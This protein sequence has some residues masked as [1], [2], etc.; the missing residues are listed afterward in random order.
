MS[1]T[2]E[3]VAMIAMHTSPTAQ[4]GTADAG[5][6]NVAVLGIAAELAIRG[7][8]VDLL[9]RAT[10]NPGVSELIP[11]VTLHELAAGPS[12]VLEKARMPEVTDE[13]GEA[14]GRLARVRNYDLLHAHYWLSGIA[15]LPVSIE[16][17]RP[18]V[19]NFH[20]LGAMKNSLAG[21]GQSPEPVQ[22]IRSEMFL[23]TQVDAIIAAS[24][25]EA[26]ALIDDVGAPPDRTWIIPP[27]VDLDMFSPRAVASHAVTRTSLGLE[28]DRP[29]VVIAGR[30]QPL[31]GHELAVRALAELHRLRGWAP[32]LVIAGEVT[33]GDEAFAGL[34]RTLA[35]E[36]GVAADVRFV[37]ALHRDALAGLLAAAALTIVPSF[38][39]T[40]G[41]V[42]LESAASGTPVLAYRAGGLP[43]AV[44]EGTSGLLLGTR[45]PRYWATEMAV[46]IEDDDRRAALGVSAR[47]FA[48]RFTWG[49]AATSLLGVYAGVKR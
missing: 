45:E 40:F 6:L 13:F 49:A 47:G 38:S 27:G 18:L 35:A 7:V 17:A 29:I 26:T 30:V 24:S 14:I 32:V 9:T 48:E 15:A 33:P 28:P 16:L 39:E 44:A 37:G 36:L 21:E 23:A 5:G 20:T 8:H 43:E 4:P 19:Q 42:A 46:L 41:L 12:G 3:R 22:R 11:G 31:K 1:V 25:A 34:L 10:G 2:V